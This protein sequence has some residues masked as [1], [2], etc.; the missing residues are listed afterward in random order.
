MVGLL[1]LSLGFCHKIDLLLRVATRFCY[2]DP[3]NTACL[4]L[5]T[6]SNTV[7][8]GPPTAYRWFAEQCCQIR[9]G[10]SSIEAECAI[11]K[12]L[13]AISASRAVSRKLVPRPRLYALC[14][15]E[16]TYCN[17]KKFCM[18]KRS[19]TDA[20]LFRRGNRQSDFAAT[21]CRQHHINLASFGLI[22]KMLIWQL[23]VTGQILY[24]T[25]PITWRGNCPQ[26]EESQTRGMSVPLFARTQGTA[27]LHQP[28]SVL[29]VTP[30]TST[31]GQASSGSRRLCL[32]ARFSHRK[33]FPPST[34]NV[35]SMLCMAVVVLF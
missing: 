19:S 29:L 11:C 10:K 24:V 13:G 5:T 20:S 15:G 14:E 32:A 28:K 16:N 21:D 1:D 27:S 2:C 30:R 22:V 6:F 12:P 26:R 35:P 8:L 9:V 17:D 7:T 23:W 33:V 34:V 18:Q 4:Y 3:I 25:V 31:A